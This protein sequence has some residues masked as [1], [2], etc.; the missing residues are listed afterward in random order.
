[1]DKQDVASGSGITA[2]R[3]VNIGDT[4]G[5]LAIGEYIIQFN[6]ENLSGKELSELIDNLNQKRM[7]E[8][9]LKIINSYNPSILPNLPPRLR[10]FVIENRFLELSKNLEYLQNHRILLISG[11]GG[12]GKTTLARALVET[13]P[14]N[15]P[16]P[17]WLDF[18]KNQSATLG[19]IL[20]KL[21]SYMNK[22]DI[23]SFKTEGRDAGQDDINKLTAE[24]RDRD[25][26]WLIFDNLETIM[27]SREFHDEG[28]DLLFTSLRNSTHQARIIVTSR[29]LPVLKNGES[30][31]DV[32][33]EEKKELKGLNID[34]GIDYLRKNGLD[35]V[36][37]AKLEELVKGVDGHPLALKLLIDIVKIFGINDALD[38]LSMYQKSKYDTIKKARKLF[39]KLAGDEKELLERIAVFRQPESITALKRMFT[40]KTSPDAL[41][42][43]I[44][45]SLL[46]TD[47]VGNYWLHPLV[48][49]FSY[50]DLENKMEI[51][52]LACEYYLSLPIPETRTKKEDV[53]SLIEAHYHACLAKEYD[54][55]A[56]IIFDNGLH[57]DLDKWGNFKMLVDL[58]SGLLPDNPFENKILLSSMV[59]HSAVIGNL[60]RA[61][62]ILGEVEKAIEYHKRALIISREIGDKCGEVIELGNLGNAYYVLGEVEKAIEYHEQGLVISHE[63]EDRKCEGAC[64]GSLGLAY[65][66][67]GEVE[68]AIDYYEQALV[69]SRMIGDRRSEGIRLG[70]LGNAYYV[71]GG[72]WKAI[73]YHE[74][75]LVISREIGDRCG[76]G[77]DL[78][79][80][81]NAYH[82]LGQ[83]EKAIDYGEQALAI[84]R[85]IGDRNGEGTR[86]SSLGLAYSVLG[87]VEKS[88]EHYNQALVIGKE[89]KDPR[90]IIFCEENLKSLKNSDFNW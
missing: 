24:L 82:V 67:L 48:Q 9:N 20:E 64:L 62:N 8:T 6:S 52:K 2:G 34:F 58:Y 36:E 7:E 19:D 28:I 47:H 33:D 41:R 49:E 54:V 13:R 37:P 65:S 89:I 84:F 72:L 35:E 26:V 70:N 1:M 3:D 83:V 40:D 15:V 11:I 74:Q 31:I 51:H 38:D 81:G 53:L 21:A 30:L 50:D 68:K 32:I 25:S 17:F 63:I 22:T 5:Q 29:T 44:D 56:D 23:A 60:A 39:D 61:Y 10:E 57:R 80:L 73:E 85:E 55:A 27:D 88:I 59:T 45:N 77:S 75:A 14:A 12:V 42:K 71:L 78:G 79:N 43:L 4:S 66:D 46:E 16:I 69:I 18:N 87:E 76:E 90:I 86:L